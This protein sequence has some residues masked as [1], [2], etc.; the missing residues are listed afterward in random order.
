MLYSFYMSWRGRRQGTYLGIFGIIVLVVLFILLYPLIVKEPTCSDGKR[1]GDETGIDC[2]GGC[3]MYCAKT[4]ALPRVDYAAVFP[5]EEDVYNVVVSLTSTVPRAAAREAKYKIYLYDESGKV[6][7]E[8]PGS[9]F[10]PTASQFGVFEAG[11]RTGARIPKRARF[12]WGDEEINFEKINVDLSK[13]PIDISS[14]KRETLLDSERL[15]VNLTNS[16]LTAIPESDYIVV[17]YDENDEPIAAS[18][19]R[20]TLNPRSTTTLFFSWPYEFPKQPKRYE[21]IKRINPF[22]YVK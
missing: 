18:K 6:I 3:M 20:E 19:T 15:T 2:G 11:I 22:N 14:W 21:L 13:F 7:K 1:N 12:S 9:T 4:V 5:V 10:I 16:A 17:V 8:I